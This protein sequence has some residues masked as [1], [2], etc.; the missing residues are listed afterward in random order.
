MSLKR[1]A[2]IEA[3]TKLY[4]WNF[5]FLAEQATGNGKWDPK[6]CAASPCLRGNIGPTNSH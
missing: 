6:Y 2:N 5:I 1:T 3:G 4:K